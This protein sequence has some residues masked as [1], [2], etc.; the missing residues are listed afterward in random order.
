MLVVLRDL[1]ALRFIIAAP[2][3]SE[4]ACGAVT[5]VAGVVLVY[6]LWYG[7]PRLALAG[8][9]IGS[10]AVMIWWNLRRFNRAQRDGVFRIRREYSFGVDG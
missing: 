5:A 4:V 10:L 1:L 7:D 3:V 2:R 9:V 8:V 6:G